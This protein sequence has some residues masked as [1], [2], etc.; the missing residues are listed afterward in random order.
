VV[1]V[2]GNDRQIHEALNQFTGKRVLVT[3]GAGAIGNNLV[4]QLVY[5]GADVVTIDN[6][7]SSQRENVADVEDMIDFI[8]GDIV[9]DS[10]LA[11]AFAR[12]VDYVFHLAALFAN[13]NSVEHPEDDL[14]TNG[15]GTLK[16]LKKSVDTAVQRF[17]FASSSC[18]Y[19]GRGEALSE[20]M[21]LALDTPYAITKALGEQYVQFFAHQ[22]GLSTAIVRYFN[23]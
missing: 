15:L 4:R 5:L 1:V 19:G 13:Q 14:R 6:L 20:D 16:L 17:V 21:E 10:V 7:S 3:G 9:A 12:P 18:V 11:R 23:S 22:Y 8:V 2:N